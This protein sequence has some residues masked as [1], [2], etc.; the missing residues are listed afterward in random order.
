MTAEK[1]VTKKWRS[2][3]FNCKKSDRLFLVNLEK[4][5]RDRSCFD[6]FTTQR[7]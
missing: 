4:K 7:R 6:Y 3:L 5:T 2:L 1:T